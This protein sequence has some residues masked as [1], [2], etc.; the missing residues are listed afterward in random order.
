MG[1]GSS[2]LGVF[3]FVFLNLGCHRAGSTLPETF[4]TA[5]LAV[6]IF[7]VDGA[8]GADHLALGQAVR[9]SAGQPTCEPL[10]Y[11]HWLA[12]DGSA[13]Y[14]TCLDM[15]PTQAGRLTLTWVMAATS[16][17]EEMSV[18]VTFDVR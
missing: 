18:P 7:Y 13:V 6:P 3:L 5:S 12:P 2:F 9:I 16:C 11:G 15:T 10:A 17:S 4:C 14:N 1:W 8:A